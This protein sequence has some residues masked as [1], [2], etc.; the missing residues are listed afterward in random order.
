MPESLPIL[1]RLAE[2]TGYP[3]DPDCSTLLPVGE[4]GT[5]TAWGHVTV[6]E[7]HDPQF[8]LTLNGLT[9]E[10]AVAVLQALKGQTNAAH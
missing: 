3:L 10:E 9:E 4:A 5:G 1:A 7:Q 8:S 6:V 2:R